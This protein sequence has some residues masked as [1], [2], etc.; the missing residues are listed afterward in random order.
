MKKGRS[1]FQVK[2]T[3]KKLSSQSAFAFHVSIVNV[4]IKNGFSLLFLPLQII[5]MQIWSSLLNIDYIDFI[6]YWLSR[7]LITVNEILKLIAFAEAS[8][9]DSLWIKKNSFQSYSIKF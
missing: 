2:Q 5:V 9:R 6:K 1:D 4:A 3:S 7:I 8:G